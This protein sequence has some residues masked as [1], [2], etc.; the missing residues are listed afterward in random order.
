MPGLLLPLDGQ[1][2]E[3]LGIAGQFQGGVGFGEGAGSDQT[4]LKIGQLQGCRL[5]CYQ[6][7]FGALYPVKCC[8]C[9]TACCSC[10]S[11]LLS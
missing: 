2:V 10:F 4:T 1:E 7:L 11:L 3:S 5:G 9:L 8:F 6:A